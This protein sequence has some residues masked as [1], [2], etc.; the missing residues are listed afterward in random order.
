[1]IGSC[2]LGF[3]E[4]TPEVELGDV[5]DKS[6]WNMGLGTEASQTTLKFGFWQMKLDP[7]VAMP[8]AGY[9]NR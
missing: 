9:A 4:N 1:M 2:R 8:T 6:Y 5:I 7:I 3:L